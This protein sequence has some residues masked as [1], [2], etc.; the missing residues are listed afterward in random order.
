M[1][2]YKDILNTPEYEFL[3]TNEH[4]GDNIIMLALGGSHAY[5]TSTPESDLDIRGIA[6]NS[7]EEILT[8]Q[9]FEQFVNEETDTTI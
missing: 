3:R 2:N 9:N 8:N 4:L 6:L 1:N 7:K 5:G